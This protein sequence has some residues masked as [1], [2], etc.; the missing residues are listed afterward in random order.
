MLGY[1][2]RTGWMAIGNLAAAF[3]LAQVGRNIG[4]AAVYFLLG[5]V[6]SPIA[7]PLTALL[8]RNKHYQKYIHSNYLEEARLLTP[9]SATLAM[10]TPFNYAV[11]I[12]LI[13][14][15]KL[16]ILLIGTLFSGIYFDLLYIVM[17]AVFRTTNLNITY[18]PSMLVVGFLIILLL[19]RRLPK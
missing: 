13:V 12:L 3:V 1:Q 8:R 14:K 18:I 10:M 6:G 4:I 15:G 9:T 11:K 19:K 5:A 2:V 7:R 16:R 17:G